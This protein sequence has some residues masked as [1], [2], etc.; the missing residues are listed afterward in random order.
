MPASSLRAPPAAPDGG[1]LFG[2]LL[3]DPAR[4][5][6]EYARGVRVAHLEVGWDQYEHQDGIVNPDY[7]VRIKRE[8][9][10]FRAAGMKVVLGVGLQYPPGWV[11]D[12][13][14]SRYVNQYGRTT[15]VM[16]LTFSQILREKAERHI[17][18]VLADLGPSNI[19]AVRIGSGGLGEALYPSE[20]ADSDR[21]AYWA[22]DTAAQAGVGLPPTV[23]V[24]PYPGWKPGEKTY[25][26]EPFSR[27]QVEEWYDW[28]LGAMV[29]G[30]N[31]QIASYKRLGFDGYHQVV[32]PSTGSRPRE[33]LRAIR[34]HLD[35]TANRNH[36]MGR[37]A[38][39]HKVIDGLAD[40]QNVVVYISSV[41][42]GSG[43]D[44][45]CES[46]DADLSMYETVVNSWSATRWLSH[47]AD[48][49]G[50]PKMGENPGPGKTG[51]YGRAMLQ[52]AAAQTRACGLQA[53]MWAHDVNPHDGISGVTLDD[54][55]AVIA[56]YSE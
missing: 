34:H 2:T 8:L 13:P 28:Y 53:L 36:T 51:Q 16:N 56:Q 52:A 27:S 19:W 12:Y 46:S 37:A 22:Y 25:N 55:S 18:R 41:A 30:I 1:Y 9:Q 11:F 50:M 6:E 38:V 48:R 5:A 7:A 14:D 47:N 43:N 54:Y 17:A 40:R 31:W 42:D 39:W 3:S 29:D 24:S 44:D 32:M 26:G 49:Y 15:R 21:D 33:Y 23:S 45:V 35:G 10:A 4:A 20:R